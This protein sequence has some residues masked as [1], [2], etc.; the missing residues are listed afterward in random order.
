MT[1]LPKA[2]AGALQLIDS[3]PRTD[4]PRSFPQDI[5]PSPSHLLV[6][7][8]D[9]EWVEG[10]V[11]TAERA[12]GWS[13]AGF[14]LPSQ[15]SPPFIPTT[16]ASSHLV[17]VESVQDGTEGQAVAPGCSEVGDTDTTV[18]SS[19]FLAPLQK[20]LAGADQGRWC[21]GTQGWA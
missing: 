2:T 6:V 11:V 1:E 14:S 10:H 8:F 4:Q 13:E 20:G 3:S 7:L 17:W 5:A 19:D 16:S 21:L 15:Q 9:V 18:A 12:L